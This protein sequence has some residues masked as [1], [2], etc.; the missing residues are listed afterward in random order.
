VSRA[1]VR[2][3]VRE[4]GVELPEQ[5]PEYPTSLDCAVCP[6]N[7][8][9]ARRAWMAKRYPEHLATAEKLH[10]AVKQAV[11]EALDGDNTQNA[12]VPI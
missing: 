9:T 7:L 10:G 6:S 12:H 1:D 8:T 4:L 11:I 5:Y 3:A 2:T